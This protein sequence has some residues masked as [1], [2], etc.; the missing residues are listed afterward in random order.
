MFPN[1]II[2]AAHKAYTKYN[3]LASVTLAQWA[4]ESGYG[5]HSPGNNPFGMKATTKQSGADYASNEVI[6]GK[7]IT[8]V[9]KF[10]V[11]ASIDEA[12][13][14]HGK[15]LATGKPYIGCNIYRDDYHMYCAVMGKIYATDPEYSRKL[16]NIIDGNNLTQY[17]KKL[18]DNKPIV[19]VMT[20][21]AG[22]VA[23][24]TVTNIQPVLHHFNY[25]PIVCFGAGLFLGITIIV[26]WAIIEHF[27][28]KDKEMPSQAFNDA[29]AGL[30]NAAQKTVA[31][32]QAQL[33]AANQKIADLTNQVTQADADDTAAVNA[34]TGQ[35]APPA[36]Q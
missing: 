30:V 5:K 19:A 31:D 29:L 2:L 7:V 22:A 32:K 28:Q 11:F 24:T 9:S 4:V 12:F 16:I 6:D 34:A 3:I 23:T 15:L 18:V 10:R 25:V 36:P 21:A 1:N 14:A 35:F 8:Q 20:L 27:N 17:D 26:M 33:D 13:D